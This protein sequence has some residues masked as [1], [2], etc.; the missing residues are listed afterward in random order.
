MI[1]N[2]QVDGMWN[3]MVNRGIRRNRKSLVP[4]INFTWSLNTTQTD[5]KVQGVKSKVTYKFIWKY[6]NKWTQATIDCISCCRNPYTFTWEHWK[7]EHPDIYKME[8]NQGLKY[9]CWNFFV[10]QKKLF[11]GMSILKKLWLSAVHSNKLCMSCKKTEL[12]SW[13]GG[14]HMSTS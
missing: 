14:P 4:P 6:M 3:S 5:H 11:R 9:G 1:R 12:F 7:W 10:C 13:S 8:C 2:R